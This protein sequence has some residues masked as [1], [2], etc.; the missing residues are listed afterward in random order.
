MLVITVPLDIQ[1]LGHRSNN[2]RE[3]VPDCFLA[4]SRKFALVGA[5]HVR[6]IVETPHV[7]THAVQRL[8]LV[9][10]RSQRVRQPLLRSH[11]TASFHYPNPNRIPGCSS[12]PPRFRS[13]KRPRSIAMRRASRANTMATAASTF[14]SDSL[15]SFPRPTPNA[16]GL[17]LAFL[18]WRISR[19]SLAIVNVRSSIAALVDSAA[20]V[21]S[22]SRPRISN[23]TECLAEA[24]TASRSL[25]CSAH[26]STY[27][28]QYATSAKNATTS[29]RSNAA[30]TASVTSSV[31]TDHP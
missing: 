22:R 31:G 4:E 17:R 15:D 9:R 12:S 1:I 27:D 11:W 25:Y 28:C 21:K 5:R 20:R 13:D 24:R 10:T 6:R 7:P 23:A 14:R 8:F 19:T 29:Q 3:P 30:R 16:F 18:M 26:V 2:Q